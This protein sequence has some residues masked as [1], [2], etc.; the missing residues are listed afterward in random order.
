[1]GVVTLE[2]APGPAR[3]VGAARLG[4]LDARGH[5]DDI[6][7]TPATDKLSTLTA[8]LW[9]GPA[10]RPALGWLTSP[11]TGPSRSGVVVA[12]PVGYAYLSSHRTLR[13]LAERLAARG[14]TVL[15]IDYDGTGDSAGDQ[16]DRDRV[17]AWRGT[18]GQAV[19]ELRRRGVETVT[20]IGVR[21]GGTLAVLEAR[22]LAANRVV[23]WSPIAAGRRFAKELRLLSQPVPPEADPHRERGTLVHTGNVFSAQTVEELGKLNANALEQVPAPRALVIDDPAGSASALA[24]RLAELGAE[25]THRQLA[26]G[27]TALETPTEFATVPDEIVT[28]IADWLGDADPS[29]APSSAPAPATATAAAFTWRGHRVRE[30]IL[31]LEPHGHVGILTEP[32]EGDTAGGPL[33]VLLNPGS[34]THVGPGR[35][36]VE[37]ARELAAFGHRTLRVDL[38][39][40]GESP[41]AGRAPGRPYDAVGEPDALEIVSELR[42]AGY[43][44]VVLS[45]L[46]ASAWIVLRA[47]LSSEPTGVIALNPQMY[48]QPGDPVEIDWDL[49]RARRADEIA[50]IERGA[51]SGLWTLLDTLGHREHAGRWLDGL[52]RSGIPVHLIFREG[53]DGII[54][55]RGRLD[56]R[57]RRLTRPGSN[58]R[59]RELPEIDHPMH[60]TWLRPRIVRALHDALT[61]I[62]AGA[63]PG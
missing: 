5:T 46:C 35:A 28:E 33:L 11:E 53:D 36:W 60:L 32:G 39:G 34:E 48:W 18:L 41:D 23:V 63:R 21:L 24:N 44:R 43:D 47:A 30:R 16:W 51:N 31:R 13:V 7:E 42:A 10:E 29:P 9:F 54:F 2:P 49:I 19:A 26:G 40:W 62:E 22:R 59:L 38:L 52:R 15:R 45:G 58:L 6:V 27:E 12:P 25:L 50:R 14:H 1:M 56:R 61:E 20:L 8:G 17:D 37:Y 3:D 55:L 4:Q 57:L